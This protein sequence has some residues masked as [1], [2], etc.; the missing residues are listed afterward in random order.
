MNPITLS[1]PGI[2]AV[3]AAADPA[4]TELHRKWL[5][6]LEEREETMIRGVEA[7][8]RQSP[9]LKAVLLIGAAHGPSFYSRVKSRAAGNSSAVRWEFD[10]PLSEDLSG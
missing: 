3:Q 9:F 2:H 1:G 5:S 10:W 6:L 8:A 4:L 7:Y